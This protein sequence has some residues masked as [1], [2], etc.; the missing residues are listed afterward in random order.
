[1]SATARPGPS[2]AATGIFR[3]HRAPGIL[4]ASIAALALTV[5]ACGG[6]DDE[7]GAP[8]ASAALPEQKATGA[9][10]KIGLINNDTSP[11]GNF[12][13][14]TKAAKAA[15]GYVNDSLGGVGGRPLELVTCTPNGSAP[16]SANCAAELLQ[17][18]PSVVVGGLDLGAGGSVPALSEAGVPY[19]PSAAINSV[20]YTS[21]NSYS[22]L[23]G[24]SGSMSA[25]SVFVAEVVKPKKVAVMFNDNPQARL[26]AEKYVQDVLKAKGVA[27][28][29]LVP[30]GNN[31]TD[32]SGPVSQALRDG[33]DMVVGIMQGSGCASVLQAKQSLG[34]TAKFLFPGSCSDPEVLK[35]AGPGADGAY[36]SAQ[37]LDPNADHPDTAAFR[38]ALTKYDKSLLASGFVQSV[39][40]TVV[41]LSQIMAKAAD[42]TSP[43]EVTAALKATAA[44]PTFMGPNV[45]CDGRQLVGLTALCTREA[46]ILQYK[47]G[48][49]T[50]VGTKWFAA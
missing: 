9:P 36:F 13:D 12:S 23:S 35:A 28:V 4:A 5:T 34:A 44:Q 14:I 37:Q 39:F 49:L 18:K 32:M 15:V 20:E 24:A 21:P 16:S 10:I 50:D 2:R 48:K 47:D 41:S 26:A 3:K 17:A 42:P 7:G 8:A 43:Q 46:R 31:E 19:V 11:L 40:G 1:M 30:Y 29:E 38:A 27:K 6:G 22:L 33:T 45:T 25:A